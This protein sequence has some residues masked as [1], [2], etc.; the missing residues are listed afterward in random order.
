MITEMYRKTKAILVHLDHLDFISVI[1]E[2][3][4]K[5]KEYYVL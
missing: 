3:S 2:R 4:S 5:G 1:I